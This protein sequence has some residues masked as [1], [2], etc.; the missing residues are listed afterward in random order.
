MRLSVSQNL[1]GIVTGASSGIGRATALRLAGR[2]VRVVLASRNGDALRE[3]AEDI[4]H[5]GGRAHVVVTDVTDPAQ[6]WRLAESV[7][8]EFGKIDLVVC[9]AGA[10]V[11]GAIRDLTPAALAKSM[12]VNFYGAVH[13]IHA[14]LPDMLKHGRGWIVAI[15]SVDGKKGLPLDAPYVAA[16]FALTGY[17]DVLRQELEGSGVTVTTVLPGRVDTPMIEHLEVPIVSAKIS[18]DRVARAVV[19]AI[20]QGRRELIIPF[21]GPK[22]LVLAN[23]FSPWLGDRLV[24]LFRLEGKEKT[25]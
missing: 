19:R 20:E 1:V 25:A 9:S 10:Y 4:A 11:R 12:A 23:A 16:K 24:R 15:T 18:A 21:S 5:A 14:V 3:L 17:M 8:A 22:F 2:G 7:R 13:M 6:V